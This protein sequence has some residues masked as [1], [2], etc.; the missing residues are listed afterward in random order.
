MAGSLVPAPARQYAGVIMHPLPAAPWGEQCGAAST[1]G[2]HTGVFR[3]LRWIRSLS[4]PIPELFQ[5]FPGLGA[6]ALYCLHCCTLVI[7]AHGGACMYGGVPRALPRGDARG[8]DGAQGTV[9]LSSQ[10]EGG[11][12][13]TLMDRNVARPRTHSYSSHTQHAR[14]CLHMVAGAGRR[15][16]VTITHWLLRP[17]SSDVR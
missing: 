17:S 7:I 15:G 5:A 9:H 16:G 4:E 10:T 2:S 8:N 14:Y 3:D 12:L 11:S 1:G 6:V 13:V